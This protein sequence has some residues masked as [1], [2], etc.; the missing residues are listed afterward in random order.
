MD[1]AGRAFAIPLAHRAFDFGMTG[2]A[3]QHDIA[4]RLGVT[5]DFHVH[6]RDQR[7]GRVEH[8]QMARGG[9]AA[10]GLRNAV[11]AEDHGRAVGHFVELV[12]EH[13]AALAQIVDDE[14]VVHDFVAHVDRRAERFERALDDLD[15]AVDAGAETAGIGEEDVHA[16]I[17]ARCPDVCLKRTAEQDQQGRAD[18]DRRI[19]DVERRTRQCDSR[20]G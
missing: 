6:F 17:L 14:A 12:D 3:D 7:T 4:A 8:A 5:R 13:R 1:G 20:L 15:R 16:P 9:F 2:V 18:A 11:R 19:G 10:H